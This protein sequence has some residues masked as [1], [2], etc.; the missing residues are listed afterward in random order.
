ML[1]TTLITIKQKEKLKIKNG[2]PRASFKDTVVHSY[3]SFTQLTKFIS[4]R[5]DEFLHFFIEKWLKILLKI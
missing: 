5:T 1:W 2:G 3:P 4:N